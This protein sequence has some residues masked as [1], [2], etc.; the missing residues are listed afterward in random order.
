MVAHNATARDAF[1]VLVDNR[2]AEHN[3]VSAET[4]LS[5]G[6]L[7]DENILRRAA[8]VICGRLRQRALSSRSPCANSR[9]IFS[10][11]SRFL[12][13]ASRPPDHLH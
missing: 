3:V 12:S 11:A 8:R 5:T 4:N 13:R 10:R 9:V 2:R 1:S 6:G 7:A